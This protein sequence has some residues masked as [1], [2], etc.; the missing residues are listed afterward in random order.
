MR[1]R[2]EWVEIG[3]GSGRVRCEERVD[4]DRSGEWVDKGE[5]V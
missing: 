5:R 2:R 4:G 3:V 1:V